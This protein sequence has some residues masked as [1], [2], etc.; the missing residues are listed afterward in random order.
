MSKMTKFI[1]EDLNEEQI[2]P[3]VMGMN[4]GFFFKEREF[5]EE[6]FLAYMKGVW[7]TIEMQPDWTVLRDTITSY[8]QRDIPDRIYDWQKKNARDARNANDKR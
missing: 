6:N 7:E 5:T 1:M 4:L 8:M 2:F 3:L